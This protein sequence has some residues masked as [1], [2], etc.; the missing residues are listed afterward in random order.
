M[1]EILKIVVFVPETHAD[2]VR[3]TIGDAGGGKI[4]NYSHNSFSI[5]GIGRFTP[6]KGAKPVI[7]RVGKLEEV[8]EERIEFVCER[9][10]AMKVLRAI[11]KVHSYEEVAFDIYSL[12][13]EDEL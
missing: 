3:R 1:S 8:K 2:A 11:R 5:K 9:K 10:N 12:V 7:G 13:S 4:G 6:K